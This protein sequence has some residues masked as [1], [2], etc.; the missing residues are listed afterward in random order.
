VADIIGVSPE[1]FPVLAL[2]AP[3]ELGWDKFIF[4]ERDLA[5]E[6]TIK[7]VTE[8]LDHYTKGGS[9]R[10]HLRTEDGSNEI[11]LNGT[12]HIIKGNRSLHEFIESPDKDVVIIFHAHFCRH[13]QTFIENF[14]K[15]SNKLKHL[16]NTLVFG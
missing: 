11:I 8:F 12:V 10:R 14:E 15:L 5:H 2:L 16:Q 9:L 13:S 6:M 4:N 1:Q 3:T 7:K